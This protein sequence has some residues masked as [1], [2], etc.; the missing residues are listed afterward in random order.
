VIEGE[1]DSFTNLYQSM[2]E[3]NSYAMKIWGLIGARGISFDDFVIDELGG[4]YVTIQSPV[5]KSEI[6]TTTAPMLALVVY[7]TL[8]LGVVTAARGRKGT[9]A[10][11]RIRVKRWY[12]SMLKTPTLASREEIDKIKNQ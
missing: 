12:D 1:T 3:N 5:T 10:I 2:N 7:G 6:T 4:T 8:L 11:S 9:Y